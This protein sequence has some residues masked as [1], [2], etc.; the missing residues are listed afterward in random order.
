LGETLSKEFPPSSSKFFIGDEMFQ[1]FFDALKN[2]RKKLAN[3]IK[4]ILPFGKKLSRDDISQLEEVLIGADVGVQTTEEIIGEISAKFKAGE[5]TGKD[6][7]D[8]LERHI[9]EIL[10][11]PAPLEIVAKPHVVLV[12]GVNGTGKTTTLGKLANKLKQSGKKVLICAADTFRAAAFE[13]LGVWA[14][15]AG[16][17]IIIGQ[18]GADPAALVFD[19]IQKATAK[20]F[21]VVL[22]DTAGRL[23]TKKNLMEELKKIARVADKA[24]PGAPHDSLLVIDASTGQNGLAQAEIFHDAIPLTGIVLTK[25]DGTAKGGIAVAIRRKLGVPIRMVGVGEKIDD[26]EDFSPHDYISSIIEAEE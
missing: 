11:E 13:Q 3:A 10:G 8:I 6:A 12:I 5:V 4:T 19:A 21:D 25:L 15:R 9:S 16:V 7:F 23:H 20:N 14:D 26:L 1:K 22:V 24:C 18:D 2:T 17:E